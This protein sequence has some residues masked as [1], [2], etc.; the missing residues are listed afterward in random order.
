MEDK[1]YYTIEE[2]IEMLCK[3][4]PSFRESLN[5]AKK[6]LDS[7]TVQEHNELIDNVFRRI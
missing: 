6:E 1:E 4:N 2:V 5:E 3:D 7:L